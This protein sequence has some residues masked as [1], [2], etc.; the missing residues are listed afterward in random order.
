M[1]TKRKL[2]CL[3]MISIDWWNKHAKL[4]TKH[5]YTV[6]HSH[7]FPNDEPP[8]I[9]VTYWGE[10]IKNPYEDEGE[11]CIHYLIL[12]RDAKSYCKHKNENQREYEGYYLEG[13]LTRNAGEHDL[14]PREYANANYPI[15]LP[16]QPKIKKFDTLPNLISCNLN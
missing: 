15:H 2:F 4:A 11:Y 16:R 6:V 12:K 9:M 8:Y 3:F 13:I 1:N 5:G 10:G 14:N 7:T